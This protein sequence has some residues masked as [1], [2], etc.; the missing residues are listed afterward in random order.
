[1]QIDD[2]VISV[3]LMRRNAVLCWLLIIYIFSF[4]AFISF[5]VL[6]LS[7]GDA[8]ENSTSSPAFGKPATP[9]GGGG[10]MVAGGNIT[11]VVSETNSSFCSISDVR[12][13]VLP[14][15]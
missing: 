14:Y 13:L 5:F 7:S 1:M 10:E 11:F 12:I 4:L 3:R 15:S 8:Y 2:V 9:G 6:E